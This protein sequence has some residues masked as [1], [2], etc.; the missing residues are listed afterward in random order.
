M[1]R[2]QPHLSNLVSGLD[3]YFPKNEERLFDRNNIADRI[4]LT[5]ISCTW[6]HYHAPWA[7]LASM[8]G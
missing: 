7:T 8:P 3:H 6:L 1:A 4:A 2:T 5:A